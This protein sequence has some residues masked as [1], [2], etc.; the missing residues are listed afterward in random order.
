MCVREASAPAGP[1][2]PHDPE[3]RRKERNIKVTKSVAAR[4]CFDGRK[5]RIQSNCRSMETGAKRNREG[6]RGKVM[7]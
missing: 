3:K 7:T 2:P 1:P 6:R 5:K 4:V